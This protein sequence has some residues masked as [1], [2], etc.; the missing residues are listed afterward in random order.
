MLPFLNLLAYQLNS[1][2]VAFVDTMLLYILAPFV[3][4]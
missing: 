2:L 4:Y 3:R 1:K